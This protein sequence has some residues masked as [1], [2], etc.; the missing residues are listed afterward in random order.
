MGL[1]FKHGTV[2]MVDHTPGTAVS[3]GD[4]VTIGDVQ[5]IAHNDIPAGKLGAV[6]WP[7]GTGVY[8]FEDD[9][10]WESGSSNISAGGTVYVD[11]G[12]FTNSASA[13]PLGV[14]LA[15]IDWTAATGSRIVHGG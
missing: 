2:L 13:D 1:N 11:S 14:A 12:E 5:C 15:D 6:A 10:G 9:S 3:A 8:E 4:V 7:S